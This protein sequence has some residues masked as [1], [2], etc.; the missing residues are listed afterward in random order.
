MCSSDLG[1]SELWV[2][3]T[4]INFCARA[5]PTVPSAH[6]DAAALAVL[7]PFLRNG[8]L[9]RAI[10]ETGGAYGGGASQDAETASFRFYSYRDPRT[11]DTLA[12]FDRSIEW[13][14]G[15]RHEARE[16]D[17]AVLN[18][19]SGIDKPGSPAGEA[20]NAWQAELFGRT[21]EWRREFRRRVLDV[22][23]E[24][25]ARVGETYLAGATPSTAV[26]TSEAVAETDAVRA[27]DLER[28]T[29]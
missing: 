4:E 10:R 17:E 6:P 2:A 20:R 18:V 29:V 5:H 7:G 11:V 24:D 13:L 14:V 3:N 12:D 9:H 15:E 1:V 19:I 21:A 8:F 22:S 28:C 23:L 16:L 25:L 26:L 27:L